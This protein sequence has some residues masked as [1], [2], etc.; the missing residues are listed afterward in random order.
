MVSL[1]KISPGKKNYGEHKQAKEEILRKFSTALVTSRVGPNSLTSLYIFNF[2]PL[3]WKDLVHR[4]LV[5][6]QG[7]YFVFILYS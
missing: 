7:I 2:E 1:I 5:E 6:I 4:T 3:V